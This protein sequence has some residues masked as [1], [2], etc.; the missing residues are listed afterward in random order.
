MNA[1]LLIPLWGLL[2]LLF[3]RYE[4][5]LITSSV[6]MLLIYYIN[7]FVYSTRG[8]QIHFNDFYCISDAMAVENKYPLVFSLKICLT[9]TAVV[10]INAI[11]IYM[12]SIKYGKL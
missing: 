6:L 4:A 9:I 10:I 12:Q 3:R 8:T 2:L 1:M 11:Y 7:R 5:A